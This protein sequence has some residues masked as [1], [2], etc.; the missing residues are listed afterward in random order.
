MRCLKPMM[1]TEILRMKEMQFTLREIG[2]ATGCSKTTA[3]EVISRCKDC[4]LTYEEA[5]KL[6]PERINELIYPDSFGRKQIKN[7]PDW[8]QIHR[9][10][11]SSRRINLQY[12]WEEEY[13]S[14]NPDGYSY[15]RFCAR[16]NKWKERSGKNVILP[17]EREPGKELFI[18]WIGDT[19]P[20]VVDYHT[21]EIHEAHFFVTT[22][23]DSS[24][25]LSKHFRM[26]HS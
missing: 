1:I 10:M 2:E 16:Y 22:L 25:H 18:D 9:R 8:E 5:I 14:D 24:F 21:S 20:C 23:G 6:T 12:I 11:L 26:R 19:L 4:G 7:E 3:G 15:S 13:R 17:Q